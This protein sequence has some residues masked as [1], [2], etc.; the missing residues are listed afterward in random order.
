MNFTLTMRECQ[1]NS[2]RRF[3]IVKTRS[4]NIELCFQQA[5][6]R[7]KRSLLSEA[8]KLN[9]LFV[10]CCLLSDVCNFREFHACLE[11]CVTF[12]KPRAGEGGTDFR[13]L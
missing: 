9:C 1:S 10:V 5:V 11:A 12:S 4:A 2:D 6:C 7:A 13:S 3:S 8:L